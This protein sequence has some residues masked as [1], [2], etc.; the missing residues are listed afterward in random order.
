MHSKWHKIIKPSRFDREKKRTNE[1]DGTRLRRGRQFHFFP[2]PMWTVLR[3]NLTF[4]FVAS[5]TWNWRKMLGFFLFFGSKNETG[6]GFIH[7]TDWNYETVQIR[8]GKKLKLTAAAKPRAVSFNFFPAE[9]DS[10]NILCQYHCFM[11]LPKNSTFD[12]KTVTKNAIFIRQF[13][14]K[15]CDNKIKK[16]TRFA[17]ETGLLDD[18]LP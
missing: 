8:S 14:L 12:T 7:E 2:R 10:F 13:L 16:W 17:Y 11:K 5:F 18:F 4:F 9:S 15:L 1:T 6:C 3:G